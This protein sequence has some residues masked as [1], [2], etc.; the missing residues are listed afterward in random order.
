MATGWREIE[1][2]RCGGDAKQGVICSE[3]NNKNPRQV[4]K[5]E[6]FVAPEG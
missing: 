1:N 6:M 3:N 4:L 5:I 2:N